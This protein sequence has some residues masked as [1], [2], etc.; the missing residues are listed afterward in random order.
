MDRMNFHHLGRDW[1]AA[2]PET[3]G[4]DRPVRFRNADPK[5]DRT[6]EATVAAEELDGETGSDRELALRRAL[7]AALVLDA[8]GGHETGLTAGEVAEATGMP[9]AAAADRLDVLEA[10]QPMLDAN[11]PRRYRTVE[12]EEEA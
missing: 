1:E 6:Y 2:I 8:L 9:E 4:D 12:P 10:V 5:D 7:E 11:G 3:P